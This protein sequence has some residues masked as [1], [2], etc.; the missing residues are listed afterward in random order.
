MVVSVSA[1]PNGP[2]LNSS[3]L[4]ETKG[5]PLE[6]IDSLFGGTSRLAGGEQL[7]QND[8]AFPMALDDKVVETTHDEKVHP[9]S[10]QSQL[11]A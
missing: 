6:E 10:A 3:F 4:P 8:K 11:R 2:R 5:V 1:L 9:S 7:H